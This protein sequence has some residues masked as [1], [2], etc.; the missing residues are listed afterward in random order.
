MRFH[1]FVKLINSFLVF[2]GVHKSINAAKPP[3]ESKLSHAAPATLPAIAEQ[4]APIGVGSGA[5]LGH[6]IKDTVNRLGKKLSCII[7]TIFLLQGAESFGQII[8]LGGDT[9][10]HALK[11][12]VKIWNPAL[13]CGYG[14]SLI[15]P[16]RF[17]VQNFKT[18]ALEESAESDAAGGNIP[19]HQKP[20]AEISTS[21]NHTNLGDLYDAVSPL[22]YMAAAAAGW[23]WCEKWRE[24]RNRKKIRSHKSVAQWPNEKS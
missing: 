11:L 9:I 8:L 21:E 10:P 7:I 3:N 18:P 12:G 1:S 24:I 15:T 23:W 6:G 19:P 16:V 20:M 13:V 22:I 14:W 5:L 2:F 17:D 4:K